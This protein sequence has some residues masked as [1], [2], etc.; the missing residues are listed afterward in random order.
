M[1][2][3][4]IDLLEKASIKKAINHMALP[5]IIGLM[6]M[7]IYN[8][9]DTMF[10]SWLGTEATGAT[11]VV[12]PIMMLVSSFG[13]MFGM[14]AGSYISRLMGMN[15][16]EKANEVGSVTFFTS[17]ASGIVFTVMAIV[18]IEPLLSFFGAS[19]EVMDLA[20]S[21]GLF[22]ILGSVFSM[23][24]MTMNNM[25]R[26][27]G[28]AKLSMI[29]MLVGSVL[30]IA[31]DPI[32]IFTL[33][34]GIKGA[35]IATTFSQMVTFIIL[36]SRYLNH[37]SVIKIGL[38]HF[39][40]H[41][42]IYK[43]VFKVGIPTFLRQLL[44]SISL[45]VLNQGAN[46]LGGPDLLAAVGILFKTIMVPMYVIFGIGQG[47]Q[48]V[49]GYNAGAG[50]KERVLGSL[51]YSLQLSFVVALISSIVLVI[52]DEAVFGIF[53][54]SQTVLSYCV[55][56]MRYYAVATVIMAVSNTYGVFYQ[57]LGKGK[58]SLILSIARQG[59]FFIPAIL[60]MPSFIGTSGILAAQ[61]A[62]D[63]LTLA[64]TLIMV[65]PFIKG[66]QLDRDLLQHKI[67]VLE[68]V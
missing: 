40:P 64:L 50:N 68:G 55:L 31:L 61:L 15:Q 51:R 7:G 48:P 59:V 42:S 49:A 56:G 39:R 14:G 44:F 53:R 36:L 37:H 62:A 16:G 30:N 28:S 8:F 35:A 33:G 22:I 34:L 66:G 38:S 25:L 12:M 46:T 57:A 19:E 9:V 47:F 13:L 67:E 26:A 4:R 10:V 54:P 52:F 18:F 23:G 6:V 20:K 21:Y 63:I 60:I 17:I 3:K 27:E 2:D 32:F 45:G 58:E 24:N 43:E 65:I 1:K 41:I 11:Q 29:G 5:A